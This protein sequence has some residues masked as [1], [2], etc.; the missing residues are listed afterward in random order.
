[1]KPRKARA[2]RRRRPAEQ[3]QRAILDA[4]E[5]RLLAAGPDALR[6]QDVAADVGVS[7]P[8]ILHHFGS[9]EGLMRAVTTRALAALEAEL[10]RRLADPTDVD[11]AALLDRVFETLG[12]RGHARLVAWL[13]LTGLSE[14]P[15]EVGVPLVRA[16]AEA[17]HA[18]RIA[19]GRAT[20]AEF[21]DSLFTILLA[22]TALFGDAIVGPQMR[23]SAGLAQDPGADQRFRAW[24]AEL[25]THHLDRST[26]SRAP[27]PGKRAR[28]PR[29]ARG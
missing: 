19:E 16:V 25:L 3:A 21:E 8:A 4:A 14:A 1:M 10:L 24:L 28:A 6:L 26:P 27:S 17:V 12:D 7:H 5:R 23:A 2:A 9:R 13:V 20:R 11:A 15:A 18:R 29:P 22:A